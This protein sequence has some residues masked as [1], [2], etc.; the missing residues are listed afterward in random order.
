[1]VRLSREREFIILVISGGAPTHKKRD[2]EMNS[3]WHHGGTT[4]SHH[5]VYRQNKANLQSLPG[6]VTLVH[7][8]K[9]L[10]EPRIILDVSIYV[11]INSLRKKNTYME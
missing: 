10:L 1:M 11:I 9:S 8:V 5:F 4:D 7:L 6:T 2:V 3:R